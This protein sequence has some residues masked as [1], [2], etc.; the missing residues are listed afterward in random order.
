[1]NQQPDDQPGAS[2][3]Y[4]SQ[5]GNQTNPFTA[6][7]KGEF[8]SNFGTNTN[9]VSQIFKEGQFSQG[10]SKILIGAGVVVLLAAGFYF[11]F[12]NENSGEDG[13]AVDEQKSQEEAGSQTEPAEGEDAAAAGDEKAVK[14]GEEAAASGE[15]TAADDTAAEEKSEES[16]KPATAGAT[17]AMPPATDAPVLSG[18]P[19]GAARGYD[20]TSGA[21]EFSWQG[22]PGGYV[23]FSRS[24]SMSPQTMKI[25]VS[26]NSYMFDHPWPGTWFWR[27]DNGAGSSEVRSFRISS[28][29]RRNIQ[30]AEPQSGG[31]IKGS[32]G[33]VS[34]TGDSG[35]AFY[36]VELTTGSWANPM[37]KFSTSGTQ[38]QLNGVQPGQ[39]QMRVG[40]FSEIAGRWEYTN[41]IGVTVQ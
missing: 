40:A 12:M 41:P 32:G 13:V 39:Y 24:R 25:Q 34:W 14:D 20:E 5:P 18:P 7:L 23:V 33:L 2:S 29:V 38:V 26:G 9:A 35:V 22:S 4:S 37:H 27:V 6:D 17:E 36:R 3:T 31:S 1:M 15:S 10:R 28:P 11:F 30:L 19:D 16:A 8:T 21:A